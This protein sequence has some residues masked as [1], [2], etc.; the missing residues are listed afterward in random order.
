MSSSFVSHF[1]NKAI[2]VRLKGVGVLMG[3]GGE[4]SE[5]GERCGIGKS[6]VA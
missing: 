2:S 4:E 6:S 3:V 5:V 1:S